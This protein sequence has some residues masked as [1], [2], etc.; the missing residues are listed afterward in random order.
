MKKVSILLLAVVFSFGGVLAQKLQTRWSEQYDFSTKK[1][2]RPSYV[3]GENDKY[4]YVKFTDLSPMGNKLFRIAALDKKTLRKKHEYDAYNTD[5]FR[6][7]KDYYLSESFVT[8]DGIVLVWVEKDKDDRIVYA[9]SL[10]ADLRTKVPMQR[11][12]KI[13]VE[14]NRKIKR[15]AKYNVLSNPDV[16]GAEIVIVE[17]KAMYDDGN[18]RAEVKTFDANFKLVKTLQQELPFEFKQRKG[19][20][21]SSIGSSGMSFYYGDD[22]NL[23]FKTNIH[24]TRDERK[25]LK[26]KGEWEDAPGSFYSV[27]DIRKETIKSIPFK[28]K[29]R[30]ILD[31][32]FSVAKEG[33]K[34]YGFYHDD[35]D[36]ATYGIT[37]IFY[38]KLSSSLEIEVKRFN[39]FTSGLLSDTFS[40]DDQDRK[41]CFKDGF[42][43]F[44][45]TSGQSVRK[46]N[47]L[48]SSYTIEKS[49]ITGQDI[50]LF[51]SITENYTYQTCDNDGN[52]T[53]HYYCLK[54]NVTC[55]KVD[56]EGNLIWAKNINRLQRYEAWD[57]MD[58]EVIATDKGYYVMYN[59]ILDQNGKRK[60]K[61]I[62]K[63][64]IDFVFFEKENGDPK[65]DVVMINASSASKG[66]KKNFDLFDI[67]SVN[68]TFYILTD[69]KRFFLGCFWINLNKKGYIGRLEPIEKR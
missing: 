27:L 43:C 14:N 42:C 50:T 3:M 37:G 29:G 15:P 38:L 4:V 62:R 5:N 69:P 60:E 34:I 33:V 22:G 51:C 23:H 8:K 47:S 53:T 41:G 19:L 39:P 66:Q 16:K 26:E 21:S 28:F 6:K 54:Y 67:Y 1:D 63:N 31:Y 68:N 36:K 13:N 24:Y 49:I 64:T 58:L 20:F 32:N 11:L 44:K 10:D 48:S 2:G 45:N 57:V 35:N 9:Q 61:D 25:E 56:L 40:D 17:E 30:D 59:S 7:Y 55:F 65:V 52:C 12:T 18:I 46:G